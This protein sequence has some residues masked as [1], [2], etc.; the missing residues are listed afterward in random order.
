MTISSDSWAAE[1]GGDLFAVNEERLEVQERTVRQIFA[2][3]D[4][5]IYGVDRGGR[6]VRGNRADSS[7]A[8]GNATDCD[9]TDS[10]AMS[11]YET[12]NGDISWFELRSG[13]WS[14]LDGPYVTVRT[15]QPGIERHTPLPELEELIERERDRV[16][17][18]LG[19]DEGDSPGRVRSLREWI[20]VGGEP[21]P[22][23]IHEERGVGHGPTAKARTVWAGRLMVYGSVVL[24]CGRGIEPADV[25]LRYLSGRDHDRFITG[26]TELLRQ[27]E[28]AKLQRMAQAR[29]G[30]SALT[31]L[32][33]HRLLIE[34]SVERALAER[35]HLASCGRVKLPRRLRVGE[36]VEQWT[37]AIRQQMR[38]ASETRR[39]AA[40]AVQLMVGQLCR[41]AEKTD[42]LVGSADGRAALEE[43]IRYTVFASQVPSLP[44]QLA[45]AELQRRPADSPPGSTLRCEAA[46]LAAWEQWRRERAR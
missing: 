16:Y 42:W 17:E 23:Q 13:D 7:A 39:E 8:D 2:E 29:R 37:A 35:A 36:P 24:L 3:L 18:Q 31:G 14:S 45:W 21:T 22:V 26:R 11:D 5:V 19:L 15:Y 38:Y 10:D 20:N 46:W 33:A 1:P 25:D 40:A 9:A 30:Q 34:S 44:A 43:V 6:G 32:D 41:L 12:L 4:F 28:I 27:V